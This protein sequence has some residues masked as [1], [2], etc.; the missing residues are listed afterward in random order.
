MQSGRKDAQS[1]IRKARAEVFCYQRFLEDDRLREF[2]PFFQTKLAFWMTT[3]GIGLMRA[4]QLQD[5][6]GYIWRS[7]TQRFHPRT[8][9]ALILSFAPPAVA[10]R[11]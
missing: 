7:L 1:K 5:A 8:A 9:I 6:R 3:L 4:N 2:H 11:V 10:C